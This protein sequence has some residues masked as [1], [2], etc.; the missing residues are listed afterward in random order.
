[1]W[2]PAFNVTHYQVFDKLLSFIERATNKKEERWCHWHKLMI[3]VGAN[4]LSYEEWVSEWGNEITTP[5]VTSTASSTHTC[6]AFHTIQML[7]SSSKL[8]S[9]VSEKIILFIMFYNE[10]I[11]W[12]FVN[13]L[14]CFIFLFTF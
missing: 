8:L 14:F 7:H 11:I 2:N 3:S 4:T 1:M 13:G 5:N 6:T 12:L 9:A 10:T